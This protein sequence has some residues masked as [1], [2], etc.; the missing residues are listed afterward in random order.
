MT[1]PRTP[2]D[3]ISTAAQRISAQRDATRKLAEEVAAQ[4][5]Q[6][7]EAT[8]PPDGQAAT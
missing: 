7:T 4:R 8:P 1:G 5:S 6:Q 2:A 3:A